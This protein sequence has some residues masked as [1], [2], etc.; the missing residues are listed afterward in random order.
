MCKEV[1]GKF[2]DMGLDNT[3]QLEADLCEGQ[4]QEKKTRHALVLHVLQRFDILSEESGI[5]PK[6][7]GYR[8]LY[9]A[10]LYCRTLVAGE[11]TL[12]QSLGAELKDREAEPPEKADARLQ[13]AM[14][15]VLMKRTSEMATFNALHAVLS[16]L[17]WHL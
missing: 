17:L 10:M 14:R 9:S 16:G 15:F 5:S 3:L 11:V 8:G 6:K 2:A 12:V 4:G 1:L 7:G 13:G